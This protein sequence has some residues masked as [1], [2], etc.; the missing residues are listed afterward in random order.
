M[1]RVAYPLGIAL[2]TLVVASSGAGIANANPPGPA[3][4][5]TNTAPACQFFGPPLYQAVLATRNPEL[6]WA[7]Y[8]A[9]VALSLFCGY[10][11]P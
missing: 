9:V 5:P 8:P 10:G 11:K 7:N 2:T 1:K 6:S 3:E 4:P